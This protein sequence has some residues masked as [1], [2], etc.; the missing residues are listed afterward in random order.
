[1]MNPLKT[2]GHA[3]TANAEAVRVLDLE[4]MALVSGGSVSLTAPIRPIPS[5]RVRV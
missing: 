4:E 5:A 1:M 2:F 3:Q